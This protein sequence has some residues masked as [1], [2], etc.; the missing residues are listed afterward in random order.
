MLFLLGA[1]IALLFAFGPYE[2]GDVSVDFDPSVLAEGVEAYFTAQEAEVSGIT[3]GVEKQV[4][5]FG[6]PEAETDWAVL[7]IHGFSAT[8]QEIRP[9]PDLVA[10]ALEANLIYTRLTGHGRDGPALGEARVSDWMRDVAEGLAAARQIGKRTLVLSVSTGGTLAAAAALD[11]ALAQDIGGIVFLSPNF[12]INSPLA[13]LLT[14]PA[15]RLWLPRLAGRERSFAPQ[16]DAQATYWTTRYPSVA[17]LTLAALVKTVA[18]LDFED[19]ALPALFIYSEADTVV[20]PDLTQAVA[21][22]WG[23]PVSVVTPELTAADDPA[24]HV[25]AGEIMSP[26]QTAP[27][28][29]AILAWAGRL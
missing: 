11:P 16:N 20:R 23:G 17:V 15:A 27:T 26:G 9:V 12:G 21:R 8:A 28:V 25:L 1:L 29:E 22:K 19:A 24:R 3:P 6:A 10:E 4:I 14:L 5:W 2:E 13:P 18:K 7:Y